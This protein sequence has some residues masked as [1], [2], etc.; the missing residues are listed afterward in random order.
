MSMINI[1]IDGKAVQVEEGTTVL[2]AAR[3]AGIDIPT[4]CYLKDVNEIG[5]CRMCVVEI[6]GARALQAACVYPVAEGNEIYTSSPAV[7]EARKSTLE[8]LLS[9]HKK[10]CLTCVRN[11]NCELQ[12]LADELN[13]TEIEFEGEMCDLPIDD[14]SRSVVRDPQKC[15][16]C[17]RCVG[18]CENLQ[19]VHVIDALNRGFK[20]EIGPAFGKKLAD[21]AC[22]NCGQCI[23]ACPVGALYEKSAIDQ[24]WDAIRDPEKVVLVQTAPAVR[25]AIGE[26]FGMPIGTAATHQMVGA[27]L[28]MGF[29]K[30]FDTDTSADLTI[31]EEGTELLHRLQNG[32]TLPLIT[33]CSP[34]WIKFAEH[35]Y[36]DMLDNLST[37]KSPH[38]MFGAVLKTYYAQEAGIDPAKIVNVSVMP[39]TA[40]KF[41]CDRPEM[42]DSGYKDVDYVLTTREL[43][44]MI[45]ECGINFQ[46][47][48]GEF[49]QPFGP[50]S[51]A[52]VIFGATG[53]VM[54]AALRTV[55]DILTG[56]DLQD[57]EYH[58][59]RGVEGVKEA[60]V[61]INGTTVKVAVAHGLGNARKVL[62]KIRAGEADWHF[63]EI[64]A[65]PGGCVNGGGQP[66]QP[67]RVKNWIDIRAERAK[68]VYSEDLRLPI[69]KSHQNDSV[70]K[71]I[72][73]GFI[74][75]PG[76]ELAH[77]LLH[78]HYT[79]RE[80]F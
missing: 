41:E 55:A 31:L 59:V 8:L 49:E 26:E 35:Y 78:T 40:K 52:G 24:V 22:V 51:G 6:K 13:I 21:V 71:G 15:I 46:E 67:A 44:R 53:G 63:V 80:R 18:A 72:Y 3:V 56:Q 68:A 73:E 27:M 17:R 28:R 74:G 47:C 20:T 39:C 62:D 76:S 65:C 75:E 2:E 66:I 23:V 37:C 25:A 43:A 77:K 1:T 33:S 12:T 34:G 64:M 48:D 45:K 10:E 9:N 50:A 58:D 36:P 19:K 57:I 61:E 69:R 14:S 7:R 60:A 42:S 11:R 16:A 4:L 54:E 79:P 30:V 38:Q 32:G 29:D 5:A 70:M